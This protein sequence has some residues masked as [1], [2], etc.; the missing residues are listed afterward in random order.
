M[1]LKP[2]S[3]CGVTMRVESLAEKHCSTACSELAQR[4]AD[5][6]PGTTWYFPANDE[7]KKHHLDLLRRA[8]L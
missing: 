6:K 1:I 7:Q 4:R 3:L 2:C 5:A 8:G